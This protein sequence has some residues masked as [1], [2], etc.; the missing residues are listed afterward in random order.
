MTKANFRL[1]MTPTRLAPL[2]ELK[3]AAGV[4]SAD[5]ST[6]EWETW[7]LESPATGVFVWGKDT[8][9]I[10][11]PEGFM[12]DFA[13][14]PFFARWWQRGGVGSQRVAAYFHDFMYSGT[15]RFS[16]READAAFYQVMKSIDGGKGWF[17]RG[18]MW[19]A[20]RV[21]GFWA[22]RSGQQ[23]YLKDRSHRRL[24]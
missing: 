14:I 12:T 10:S 13:S 21:G 22:Y 23:A 9:Y 8:F 19:A 1:L 3:M 20:L 2:A 24:W 6:T 17:K 4:E 18:A 5:I 15:N 11:V 7:V 16:R